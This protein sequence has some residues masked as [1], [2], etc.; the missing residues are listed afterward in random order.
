MLPLLIGTV[1]AA[2]CIDSDG[3]KD[4]HTKGTTTEGS[5]TGTDSCVVEYDL[6]DQ[7]SGE[8]CY[9]LEHYCDS[10][11]M[12]DDLWPNYNDLEDVY[13]SNL[14]KRC[15]LGCSQGR[16]LGTPPYIFAMWDK[17]KNSDVVAISEVIQY[18]KKMGYGH[19]ELFESGKTRLFSEVYAQRTDEIIILAI[20]NNKAF[21]IASDSPLASFEKFQKDIGRAL[22]DQ[23]IPYTL[24]SNSDLESGDLNDLFDECQTNSDCNDNNPSTN[25]V[26]SGSPKRCSNT[27]IVSC[28]NEDNYC[29]PN[30]DFALDT[31]CDECNSNQDCDDNNACTQDTC[32][33][34]PKRCTNEQTSS[35]CNL[36]GTC[37]PIGTRTENQFCGVDNAFINQQSGETNCNNNYEC[38]SNICA[39]GQCI[40]QGLFQKFIMWFKKLFGG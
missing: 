35:G 20:K 27:N 32:S 38:E 37:V 3:G 21:I 12:D 24:L 4:I 8:D 16:C 31:D 17:A 9:F 22:D 11:R 34:N 10:V 26:C 15:L 7:C 25:D 6:V 13:I 29:P 18:L 40:E 19:E 30:C 36:E 33:G 1:F 23:N 14:N 2:D 5:I 28:I 39:D